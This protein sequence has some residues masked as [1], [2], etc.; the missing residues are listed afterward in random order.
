MAL[1]HRA[2]ECIGIGSRLPLALSSQARTTPHLRMQLLSHPLLCSSV[3]LLF[4]WLVIFPPP[5]F[6]LWAHLWPS[7]AQALRGGYYHNHANSIPI[8]T[9]STLLLVYSNIPTSYSN[10]STSYS[11]VPTPNLTSSL[12]ILLLSLLQVH[13]PFPSVTYLSVCH[14]P[15]SLPLP[16]VFSVSYDTPTPLF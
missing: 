9:N 7:R 16:C 4:H 13:T 5:W 8:W 11:N 10:V 14:P 12:S 3:A 6:I 15:S 1:G 2:R